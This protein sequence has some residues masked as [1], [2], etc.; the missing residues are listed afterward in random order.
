M[1]QA[2]LSLS[3][4][5][6]SRPCQVTRSRQHIAEHRRFECTFYAINNADITRLSSAVSL[7][8]ISLSLFALRKKK[9]LH[10]QAGLGKQTLTHSH[11][12]TR[13]QIQS[14]CAETVLQNLVVS[15]SV[16]CE[17]RERIT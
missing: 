4:G 16:M 5:E 1:A 17:S 12:H 8:R 2:P 14:V 10:T 11:T 3:P 13:L 15:D 9:K 7:W 6:M